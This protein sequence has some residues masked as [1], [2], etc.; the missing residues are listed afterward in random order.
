M[1]VRTVQSVKLIIAIPHFRNNHDVC[2]MWAGGGGGFI[3]TRK[4]H[5]FNL[6][7]LNSNFVFFDKR[8]LFTAY[9]ESVFIDTYSLN[10]IN[11][12][13]SPFTFSL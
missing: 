1:R 7:Q 4:C 8:I 13:A 12:Y 2:L 11:F 5:Y 10:Y 6:L 3:E 9:F